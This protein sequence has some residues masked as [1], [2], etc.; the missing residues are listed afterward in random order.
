MSYTSGEASEFWMGIMELIAAVI[1]YVYTKQKI[2]DLPPEEQST[3]KPLFLTG[4]GIFLLGIASLMTFGGAY[5]REVYGVADPLQ[6]WIFTVLFY[7]FLS[8]GAFTM[9]YASSMILEKMKSIYILI[10]LLLI[11]LVVLIIGPSIGLSFAVTEFV[12]SYPARILFIIPLVMWMYIAKQ[13][14]TATSISIA[15]LSLMVP[16]FTMFFYVPE[17]LPIMIVIFLRLFGPPFASIAFYSSQRKVTGELILYAASYAF[18]GLW[19]TFMITM[20]ITGIDQV[21]RVVAIGLVGFV[22]FGTGAYTYARWRESKASAT[23]TLSLFFNISALGF[24]MIAM[25]DLNVMTDPFYLYAPVTLGVIGTMFM[26]LSVFIALDWKRTMLLPALIAIPAVIFL[27]SWY[28]QDVHTIAMYR[29]MLMVVNSI[30][31]MVPI[32]LYFYLWLRMKR[33]NRPNRLRPLSLSIALILITIANTGG[34]VSQLP[35]CYIELIGMLLAWVGL[36]GRLDRWLSKGGV[37]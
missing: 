12:A 26:S 8:L 21:L 37:Q 6:L 4:G 17:G 36:T 20:G 27:I 19:M 34:R 2:K 31:L 5:A 18:T 7:V 11:E 30:N 23:L 3:G 28:P 9:S 15:Y 35:F 24:I 33:A 22:S 10:P 14:K 25:R 16:T 13:T 32:V 29:P 1:M